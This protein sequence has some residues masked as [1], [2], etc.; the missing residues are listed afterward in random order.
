MAF[1]AIRLKSFTW[2]GGPF[3]YLVAEVCSTCLA[4]FLSQMMIVF[5]LKTSALKTGPSVIRLSHS[6]LDFGT[7]KGENNGDSLQASCCMR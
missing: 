3:A 7:T 6:Q 5:S 4:M 2:R 1:G